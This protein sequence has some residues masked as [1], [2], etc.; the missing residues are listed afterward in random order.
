MRHRGTRSV[1]SPQPAIM[2]QQFTPEEL[3]AMDLDRK[4]WL[5]TSFIIHG[6]PTSVEHQMMLMQGST[7]NSSAQP[8]SSGLEAL[9]STSQVGNIQS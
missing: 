3:A 1:A 8:A 9:S 2:S 7:G 4:R 6:V 5:G